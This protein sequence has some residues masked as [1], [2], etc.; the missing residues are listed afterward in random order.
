MAEELIV[1]IVNGKVYKWFHSK[2]QH[3]EF[4]WTG[5]QK[6]FLGLMK[7]FESTNFFVAPI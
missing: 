2:A 7:N 3:P 5:L 1:I 6:Q 4:T